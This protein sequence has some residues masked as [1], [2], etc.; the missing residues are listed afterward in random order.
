MENYLLWKEMLRDGATAHLVEWWQ[1]AYVY[2]YQA[3]I[4]GD[5]WKQY[6]T[7]VATTLLVTALALMIG[8]ILGVIVAMVRTSHDQ[9]HFGKR[10]PIRG[11]FNAICKVYVTGRRVSSW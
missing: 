3:F 5:R 8:I 11:F 2:F 9:Q 6:L 1:E 7:G 10:K 4:E